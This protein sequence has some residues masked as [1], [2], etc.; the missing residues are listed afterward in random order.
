MTQPTSTAKRQ[1][2]PARLIFTDPWCWLGFG[3]GSGLSPVAPGTLG[4]LTA[5]PLYVWLSTLSLTGYVAIVV[6]LFA[7]GIQICQMSEERLGISDHSGI[8]WDEIVGY[9]VTMTAVPFSWPAAALGFL[10]FRLFDILKPW[11]I[12]Q[13]DRT[14]HGGF[15]IMLDDLLA[16][17]FAAACLQLARPWLA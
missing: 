14:V 1:R 5:L 10:L 3:F 13:F 16:G 7:L 6:L 4:T 11:P 2:I 17:I 9:L 15:G 8:V 12:R